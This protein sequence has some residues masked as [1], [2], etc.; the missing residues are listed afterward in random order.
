[1]HSPGPQDGSRN[2]LKLYAEVELPCAQTVGANNLSPNLILEGRE[3]AMHT[4]HRRK[5]ASRRCFC[6][7]ELSACHRFL[8]GQELMPQGVGLRFCNGSL[9][10]LSGF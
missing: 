10:V 5:P 4:H 7:C 8:G 3:E 1:M 2:S 9:I 6:F